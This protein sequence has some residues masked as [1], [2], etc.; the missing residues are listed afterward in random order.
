MRF[1]AR[2]VEEGHSMISTPPMPGT[3]CP[4]TGGPS[5]PAPT[6]DHD[7]LATSITDAHGRRSHPGSRRRQRCVITNHLIRPP[8]SSF[9]P[10]RNERRARTI[11]TAGGLGI[12]GVRGRKPGLPLFRSKP[13]LAM[14]GPAALAPRISERPRNGPGST[15]ISWAYGSFGPYD[16]IPRRHQGTARSIRFG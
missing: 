16:A 3:P 4:P 11:T 1:P 14:G 6:G 2:C 13:P 10:R 15:A 8:G 7:G 9:P 5:G 12:G